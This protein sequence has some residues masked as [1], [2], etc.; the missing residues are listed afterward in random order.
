VGIFCSVLRVPITF[1]PEKCHG[2][3]LSGM[4]VP[5]LLGSQGTFSFYTTG[6]GDSQKSLGG[7][8]I[9]VEKTS[10]GFRSYVPGPDYEVRNGT[11]S[12]RFPFHVRTN[13]KDNAAQI[14]V[15]GQRVDLKI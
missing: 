3:V 1:P 12:S 11:A 5:D 14:E 15:D 8:R 4:C 9:R 7:Q 13:G 10:A 2:L 6:N